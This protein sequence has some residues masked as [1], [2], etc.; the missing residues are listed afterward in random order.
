[1]VLEHVPVADAVFQLSEFQQAAQSVRELAGHVDVTRQLAEV[2]NADHL[3]KH[4]QEL[5]REIVDLRAVQAHEHRD[6]AAA[7]GHGTDDTGIVEVHA[8]PFT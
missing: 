5:S 2:E 1:M 3:A 7:V 4:L 6:V 8:R